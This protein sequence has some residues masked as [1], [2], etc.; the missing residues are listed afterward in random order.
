MADGKIRHPNHITD[1]KAIQFIQNSLPPE[2]VARQITPDYGIDLD[3]E[4]FGY[5]DNKCVTLGEHVFLQVKGTECAQYGKIEV[6]GNT[7]NILTETEKTYIEVLKFPIDVSLLT[8]VERMG[9]G[10][11]VLLIVVDLMAAKA[12]HICLNDYIRYVLPQQCSNFREQKTVTIYIPIKNVISDSVFMWYGKRTKIYSLFQEINA[13]AD[14]CVYS[15]EAELILT[16][17]ELIVRIKNHDAWT[18]R[19]FF[20]YMSVLYNILTEMLEHDLITTES[21]DYV[22]TVSESKDNWKDALLYSH[23]DESPVKGY[24]LAQMISCRRF[25]NYA[26]G[27]SSY[28]DCELRQLWLPTSSFSSR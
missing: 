23:T 4:L 18:S 17:R 16:I 27:M 19:T 25:L 28:F 12:F 15:T 26:S 8:L 9:S 2:W 24:I 6:Y 22:I 14:K 21:K 3:L 1:S 20:G 13:V 10:I 11:P 7:Y 5:E